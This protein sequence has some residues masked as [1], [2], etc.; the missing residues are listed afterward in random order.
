MVQISMWQQSLNAQELLL[1]AS[2]H[3]W[4]PQIHVHRARVSS[5]LH[6]KRDHSDFAPLGS[7]MKW[8]ELMYASELQV[9]SSLQKLSTNS[10]MPMFSSRVQRRDRVT[11]I[12]SR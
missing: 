2:N 9:G 6:Q 10:D 12:D 4:C 5:A 11:F 7:D 8:S 3:D 1:D